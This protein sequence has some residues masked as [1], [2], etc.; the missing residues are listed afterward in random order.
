[1]KKTFNNPLLKSALA[2]ALLAGVLSTPL[3]N[4]QNNTFQ[5]STSFIVPTVQSVETGP[6]L[7]VVPYV[8]ADGYTINLALIPSDTEFAGYAN[9]T[10]PNFSSGQLG[11]LNAVLAPTAFPT[12]TVRQVVTTVNV[13]DNQTVVLGDLI[14]SSVNSTKNKLPIVGDVPLLGRLF[15]SQSKQTIKN[16]LM[17]FVTATIVDPAGSRVHTDDELPF[18]QSAVPVQPAE[19]VPPTSSVKSFKVPGQIQ[20]VQ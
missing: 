1:M 16:N 7:D 2:T 8:L 9:P 11:S 15:Q 13:W 5:P 19:N 12:F 3:A 10:I 6:I 20:A 18:A 14:T 4:A 17:I